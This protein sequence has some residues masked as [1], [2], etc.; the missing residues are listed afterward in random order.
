MRRLSRTTAL[1]I[2][3]GL[4]LVSGISGLIASIPPLWLGAE[5]I[6]QAGDTPPYSIFVLGLI[7]S[8]IQIVGAFGAWRN[9]RWG[10]V[11]LLLTAAVNTV[12]A[13]PGILFA[14]T[15]AF[16]LLAAVSTILGVVMIVLCLWRDRQAVLT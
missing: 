15:P 6:N 2:A 3:A 9:Q 11:L 5:A 14:P 10:V 7:L 13:A 12:S 8:P 1:R 4:A 16:Q